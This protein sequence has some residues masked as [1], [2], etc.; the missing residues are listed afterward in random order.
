MFTLFEVVLLCVA[1]AMFFSVIGYC[2]A[3]YKLKHTAI[4]IKVVQPTLVFDE[5]ELSC[6]QLLKFL[7]EYEIPQLS[8][9]EVKKCR[10]YASVIMNTKGYNYES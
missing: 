3:E 1:V 8:E 7:A 5:D 10:K 9:S 2:V 6:A 4:N